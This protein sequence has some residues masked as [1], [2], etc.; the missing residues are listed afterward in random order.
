MSLLP[1]AIVSAVVAC[2]GWPVIKHHVISSPLDVLNGPKPSSFF[3][4]TFYTLAMIEMGLPDTTTGNRQGWRNFAQ[5]ADAFGRAWLARGFFYAPVLVIHDPKALHTAMVKDEHIWQ[6]GLAPSDNLTLLLGPGVLSTRAGQHKRQRKLLNPVFSVAHLR[7]M[8]HIF[9]NVA[10]RVHAALAKR[11][12]STEIA[13]EVDINGWMGHITLEMLGQAGLGYSF[14]DFTDDKTDTYG[15][16]IKLFFPKLS[17]TRFYN[18]FTARLSWYLPDPVIRQI[19]R[20]APTKGIRDVMKI[21][22]TMMQRSKEIV[23]EKK[24]KLEKG[25]AALKHEVGE[26]KDIMSICLRANMAA[27]DNE[28]MT[29]E[30]ILAQMSTFILAGMDTTSNALSRILWLL[31]GR[32]DVQAKLRAEIVEAQ[33][34]LP[35]LDAVCRETLRVYAPVTLAPRVATQD[36][37]IPFS[38]PVRTRDGREITEI[39]APRGT[40]A[41]MHYQASNTDAALWGPDAREWKP[42]RWLAPLPAGLED[43]RIP[44]V[45]AHLMTFAA[46]TRSCI[47][48]K[49]SQLEMKIVLS[50]LLPAF[51]FELTDKPVAWNSSAVIYPTMGEESSKPELLLMVKALKA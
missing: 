40:I 20:S 37:V 51:S 28:K 43:A 25:D 7:D 31:S 33:G 32:Q 15:E 45:Y 49:F 3:L 1:L 11:I 50:V 38:A 47:G 46:G 10:H 12:P 27:A 30:E 17:A 41:L 18:L 4:G 5:S 8:T 9:Y 42:E 39:A 36:T 6:K 22:D 34:G 24:A 26:G 21:S 29:D 14:D 44:G 48:F 13:Q 2:L 35:Y 23:A 19:G 16:S